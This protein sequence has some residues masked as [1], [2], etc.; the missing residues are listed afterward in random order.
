MSTDLDK[1][2]VFI[3]SEAAMAMSSKC[4]WFALLC[5]C[6][7]LGAV[8]CCHSFW[9]D[10]VQA[11]QIAV[12]TVSIS[13]MFH[14]I[15]Y[16]GHPALWFL[17]LRGASTFVDSPQVMLVAHWLFASL[18]AYLILWFCPVP[19]WQ[20]IACCFG[21]FMLFEYGVICRDYALTA[22][23]AFLFAAIRTQNRQAIIGPALVLA[24]LVHTTLPGAFLAVSLLA[25]VIAEEWIHGCVLERRVWVTIIMVGASLLLLVSYVNPPADSLFANNYRKFRDR[26]HLTV[27]SGM[28]RG[29]LFLRVTTPIPRLREVHFW[30]TNWT[31]R[32]APDNLRKAIQYP[33]TVLCLALA[34]LSIIHRRTL[35]VFFLWE[36]CFLRA[37][38]LLMGKTPC[39][40]KASGSSFW[41]SATGSIEGKLT[42][43]LETMANGKERLGVFSQR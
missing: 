8:L 22:S 43:L 37:F 30:N 29:R 31:D 25:Y 12:R 14:N 5:F 23:L 27:G 33:A 15:R 18:N 3:Q 17:I 32:I 13:E 4:R 26:E 40:I 34:A 9:R 16:E 39:A 21:Y 38:L 35:V 1:G 36:H 2:K 7:L 20:R 42:C 6:T 24:L 11:W 41:C 28:E 19:S 10:E